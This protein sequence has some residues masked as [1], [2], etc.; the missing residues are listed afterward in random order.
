MDEDTRYAIDSLISGKTRKRKTAETIRP[1]SEYRPFYGDPSFKPVKK[2]EPKWCFNS[3]EKTMNLKE[4][5]ATLSVDTS[6]ASIIFKAPLTDELIKR[7]EASIPLTSR[8]WLVDKR[9]WRFAPSVIAVLKP[10]LKDCYKDVQ[11]LGVPKALPSTKFDQLMSK[12]SKDDKASIY[13]ILAS[14]YHPDKGGSHEVMTLI[15]IVFR[16]S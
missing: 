8:E 2:V 5:I 12:L 7:I 9:A 11:M 13:R 6:S 16:G 3:A 1:E 10:I 15:N 4:H 14:K